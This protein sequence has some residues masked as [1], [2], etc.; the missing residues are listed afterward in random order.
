ILSIVL[1]PILCFAVDENTLSAVCVIA[2]NLPLALGAI[3]VFFLSCFSLSVLNYF[4][5]MLGLLDFFF[6]LTR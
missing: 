1:L 3:V 4:A 6:F 5:N 2:V